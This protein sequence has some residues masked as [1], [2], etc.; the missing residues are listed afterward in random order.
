MGS[1][2]LTRRNLLKGIVAAG[3]APYALTSDALGSAD[4]P[5]AGSRITMGFVGLGPQGQGRNLG[6]AKADPR[7]QP[8]ALCDCDAR[9]L[10]SAHQKAPDASTHTD[11]R[12]VVA[13]DGIDAV[14]V[15][16]PDH[17][18]VPVSLAAARAGKDIL[19]EKPLTWTIR[20]GRILSETVARYG[21]VFQTASEFRSLSA[22]HHGAELVRNG[23]IGHL[24][25][26]RVALGRNP[27]R[28]GNPEPMEVPEG[29]D[30]DMWLGPAP[31][32][33]YTKDRCHFDFRWLL[34]YSGGMLTDWGGHLLDQ[35][36]W[37]N[38]SEYT[39]PVEID[40][41]GHFMSEGLFDTAD[42][43]RIEYT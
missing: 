38:D 33:P 10:E 11:W 31:W 40:G 2:L 9:R 18:H 28:P 39:G 21:C 36:Q 20:E 14:V 29:F 23:R 7:A 16:T 35:A 34:D 26:I 42:R 22:F 30:Y 24:H 37:A 1:T 5:P 4:R 13:A 15:S 12:E 25:T 3:A 19:C 32:A 41:E 8:V 27:N 43:F 6:N 17:W